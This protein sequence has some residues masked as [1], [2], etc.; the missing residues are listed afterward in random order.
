MIRIFAGPLETAGTVD[1]GAG[2]GGGGAGGAGVGGRRGLR[3]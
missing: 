3:D 2:E 1:E